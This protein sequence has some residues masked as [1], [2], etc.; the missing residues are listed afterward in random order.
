MPHSHQLFGLLLEEDLLQRAF[1]K[2]HNL[3]TLIPIQLRCVRRVIKLTTVG[4][5]HSSVVMSAPTILRLRVRIP[6][7]PSMLFPFVLLKL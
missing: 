6:R 7:T 2:S 4:G 3:V 1:K 5:R